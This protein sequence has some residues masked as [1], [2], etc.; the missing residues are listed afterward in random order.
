MQS[1]ETSIPWGNVSLERFLPCIV[2]DQQYCGT[3]V[4]NE[5]S[6]PIYF[7]HTACGHV[8][9]QRRRESS[10]KNI[11][12]LSLVFI[13]LE[14]LAH[15]AEG[16]EF[17]CSLCFLKHSL[18]KCPRRPQYQQV[19][20]RHLPCFSVSAD[21]SLRSG[22]LVLSSSSFFSRCCNSCWTKLHA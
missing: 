16:L 6:R 4:H 3:R 17:P 2:S 10:N 11:L 5:G 12:L 1:Q 19:A 7:G 14:T 18:L 15:C 9:A 20:D 22:L 8:N 13:T 21:L